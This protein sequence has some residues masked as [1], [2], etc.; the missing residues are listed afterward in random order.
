MLFPALIGRTALGPGVVVDPSR[1]Y[2]LGR[3]LIERRKS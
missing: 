1:R 3:S 2:L